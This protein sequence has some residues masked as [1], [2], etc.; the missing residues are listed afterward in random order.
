MG[1][2]QSSTSN[3][4]MDDLAFGTAP[5][6]V[7]VDD[8][9]NEVTKIRSKYFGGALVESDPSMHQ[10]QNDLL[11]FDETLKRLFFRRKKSK[12]SSN[13]LPPEEYYYEDQQSTSAAEINDSTDDQHYLQP[14][15][16]RNVRSSSASVTD[17]INDGITI[18][19][20]IIWRCSNCTAENKITDNVCRRCKLA[21]TKL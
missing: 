18:T 21:E 6:A 13:N 20:K 9:V 12:Q 10:M 2:N 1:N 16:D 17:S 3:W 5:N 19:K 11:S 8:I 15:F 4:N 14:T 7:K